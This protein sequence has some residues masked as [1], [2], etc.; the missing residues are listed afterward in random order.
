MCLYPKLLSPCFVSPSSENE[1]H[2][3]FAY[4][5][6]GRFHELALFGLG[7]KNGICVIDVHV[8][9]ITSVKLH[10][11]GKATA[12]ISCSSQKVPSTSRRP[13]CA[14][15]AVNDSGQHGRSGR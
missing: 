15:S 14:H 11:M 4:Q 12:I 9:L 13:Q 1:L 10:E 2:T 8:D 3:I 7:D 6:S 5:A